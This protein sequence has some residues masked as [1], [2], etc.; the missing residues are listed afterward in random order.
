MDKEKVT[1]IV[2]NILWTVMLV[3]TLVYGLVSGHWRAFI[4]LAGLF[5][6]SKG[7]LLLGHLKLR[8]ETIR[9]ENE[10][11]SQ[12]RSTVVPE[13]QAIAA[14]QEKTARISEEIERVRPPKECLRFAIAPAAT[15]SI[16]DSKLGG[17]PYWDTAKPYPTDATGNPMAMVMQVNLDKSKRLPY[18]GMLQFF[19]TSDAEVLAEGYGADYDDPTSQRN[20]R[21]V[22]HENIDYHLDS[23]SVQAY[24][25]IETQENTPVFGEYA[26]T[27][28]AAK[29]HIHNTDGSFETLFADAVR[30]LFGDEMK[31]EEWPEEYLSRELP[32]EQRWPNVDEAL[33]VGDTPLW[34]DPD[35][36]FQLLGYP[37]FIQEDPREKDSPFDTLLLQIPT[38]GNG[39]GEQPWQSLWGDC[40]AA[41][42][43]INSSDL[44]NRDFSHVHYEVQ[45][46]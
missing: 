39:E 26:L 19:I 35:R 2:S 37:A 18:G 28:D 45:C 8:K 44:Q 36:R 13:P 43:F 21:V 25:T 11:A 22:Y 31:E 15:P 14:M 33:V 30:R 42:L 27:E 3:A 16:Y 9:L 34:D 7:V 12:G 46:Y 40:G 38:I 41:Y 10:L 24:P 5:V 29:S 6:I 17:L 1:G 4:F 20:F 23:A 32:E